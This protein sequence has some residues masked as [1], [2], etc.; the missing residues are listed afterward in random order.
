MTNLEYRTRLI[1]RRGG[2]RGRGGGGGERGD[3]DSERG[4]RDR[5]RDRLRRG[6]PDA[7]RRRSSSRRRARISFSLII[8]LNASI[9]SSAPLRQHTRIIV[10]ERDRATV[11]T[12]KKWIGVA[13]QKQ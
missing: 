6:E 13:R 7:C 11:T 12:A 5:D 2:D 8:R 1:A 4:D 9:G 10:N 3:R